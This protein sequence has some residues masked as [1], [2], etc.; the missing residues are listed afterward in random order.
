MKDIENLTNQLFENIKHI[1]V[2]G[3]E[4]WSAREL[5]MVLEYKEWRKFGKVIQKAMEACDGSN[6][7][8]L[9]HFVFKDKMVHIGSNT[10]RKIDDY[11][12]SRYACYL[13]VQNCNPRIKIIAFAQTYFA[14]QTRK[15][16]LF[17]D[18]YEKLSYDEKRLYHRN[19]IKRRNNSLNKAALK[20]GVKDL[21][22]FHNAGY[23][24]LYNGETANDIAKRKGLK[25][26]EDILD[27]MSLDEEIANSFRIS[28]TEQKLR[29][30]RINNEYDANS[31]HY[32]VG[33]EVRNT[34][35]KVGGIMPEDMPT[36]LVSAKNINIDKKIKEFNEN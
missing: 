13:I 34:I 29:N 11:K 23:K 7:Y 27:Y 18:E 8:L 3:K 36:P 20:S 1:D 16:E 24:G 25:Y 33:E 5:M 22:R 4:Y 9:D 14:V 6:H 15:Q 21:A 10:S 19:I 32:N 26:R 35:E 31:A 30:E 2:C 28:L 12:L 17:E